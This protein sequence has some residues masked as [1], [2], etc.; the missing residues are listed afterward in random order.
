MHT[1]RRCIGAAPL[2]AGWLALAGPALAAAQDPDGWN[3]ARALRLMEMARERRQQPLAD[4]SL[5]NYQARAEGL[6]YFYLER[7]DTN[8]RV[9]VKTDQ[10]ALEVFW[11]QPDLTKQRIVGLRDESALPNRMHYHLDH[12][13]VVQNG[14]G[15]VMRMGDGDEVADVPH[16]AAPASGGIYDF[17]LIDSLT[18]RL[19]GSPQPVKAYRIDVRPKRMDQSAIVGSVFVDHITGD[20]VRMTFTFTP[21]SY[22]D[23]RLE[24]I[25]ISLD[26]SL[27]DGRYWLPYEQSV[28]IRRQIPELDFVATSVIQGRFRVTDYVFNQELDPSLFWGYRVTT[29]PRAQREAYPFSRGLYEELHEVGLAPPPQMEELRAQAAELARQ[30]VLSGLPRLRLSLPD[31]SQVLRYDRAG[32]LQLGGGFSFAA[33]TRTRIE[34]TFGWAFGIQQPTVGIGLRYE[35]G[36]RTVLLIEAFANETRDIGVR[37]GAPGAFNTVA[38]LAGD[39]FLDVYR[40][41]GLRTT[42]RHE[43]SADWSISA[44]A[45]VEEHEPA[46]LTR[47]HGPLGGTFRSVRPIDDGV[48]TGGSL[49]FERS[50]RENA[51]WTWGT[52]VMLEA[53]SLEGDAFYGQRLDVSIRRGSVQRDRELLLRLAAGAVEGDP[54]LQA[55]ALLGG[56]GTLPGYPYRSLA[57]DRYVLLDGEAAIEIR[58]PFVRARLL[59]AAGWVGEQDEER[60]TPSPP[61]RLHAAWGTRSASTGRTAVGA[62]V[63]LFWDILRVDAVRGLGGGGEWQLLLSVNPKLWS[64][65]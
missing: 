41:D 6:V 3:D 62:G 16:P 57:G 44:M 34:N 28:E 49:V 50:L 54:P 33:S 14:F 9:L 21:A 42:L 64:V 20:I 63:G 1:S 55:H 36:L 25:N 15:D 48:R 40:A 53:A 23:R 22:V 8:E 31:A 12:L 52:R 13:T 61:P 18:L 30:R 47:E 5:A 38:A 60:I 43:L 24:R 65:L 29:V 26:N 58:R 4:S 10:V 39:D 51:G 46:G 2:V 19:P 32:G 17:R 11:A 35:S 45:S 56:R 37:P 59:A 7:R 27:R